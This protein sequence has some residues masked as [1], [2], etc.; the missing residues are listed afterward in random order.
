[1]LNFVKNI[2]QRLKKSLRPVLRRYRHSLPQTLPLF[3]LYCLR[4]HKLHY[5]MVLAFGLVWSFYISLM[6]Y[7]TK[8]I[9]DAV[10][11]NSNDSAAMVTATLKP[12]IWFLCL[13]LAVNIGYRL[14]DYVVSKALP[15]MQRHTYAKLSAYLKRHS[16]QY[17]LERL[18]G[19]LANK[20]SDIVRGLQTILEM[21]ESFFMQ[22]AAIIIAIITM[23]LI[24]PYF[25][26]ILVTWSLLFLMLTL[27]LS[28][29]SQHYARAFSQSR[30]LVSGRLVDVIQN[31]TNT[32]IFARNEYE[33][34]YLEQYLVEA[35]NKDRALQMFMLKA[36]I[37]QAIITTILIAFMLVTLIYLRYQ[38]NIT[39]GD[40]ALVLG[41]SMS[42]SGMV[43]TLGT[44]LVL[45]AREIGICGQALQTINVPHDI[46]DSPDAKLLKVKNAQIEFKNVSFS[47][48]KENFLSHK[49]NLTINP[50]Q[51]V[52]LVGCSGGGKT[53][54]INLILRLFSLKSG[55]IMIDKQDISSVTRSSLRQHISYIPQDPSLFHRSIMENIRYGNLN[56]SDEQVIEAAKEASCHDFISQMTEGYNTIV[57]ERGA[58]LS[59]GQR[60]RIA[61]ARAIL[62]DAPIFILDEATS[63]LDSVT[64][65]QIQNT[66]TNIMADKTTLVVAHRLSTLKTMDRILVFKDGRI[67]EDGS[68]EELLKNNKYFATLWKEQVEGLFPNKH[69]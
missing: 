46:I 25:A 54:F 8:L 50:K 68:V 11:E 13:Y 2:K 62:R 22:L 52:G 60:Q 56:A 10:A 66:L 35:E 41:L 7:I 29:H 21:C 15:R 9:I 17:F 12:T 14:R 59:G 64:E 16:H 57:G 45:F 36:R 6:P 34:A 31:I 40:F 63:A 44:N 1:M 27:S 3:L 65:S 28:H 32:R 5:A 47:Y 38:G 23:Y 18:A 55:K 67:I 4:Q 24:H 39:V 42:I 30:S 53:S 48:S 58:R 49:L 33:E 26:M 69:Q 51:T 20:V 37:I 61:I 19:D 43:W